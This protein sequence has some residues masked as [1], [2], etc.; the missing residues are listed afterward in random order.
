VD[1]LCDFD[2]I[3]LNQLNQ[4]YNRF[5]PLSSLH[6]LNNINN[7][8][9]KAEELKNGQSPLQQN[10]NM[11]NTNSQSL[12]HH[13]LHHNINSSMLLAGNQSN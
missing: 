7:S 3:D 2:D 13:F 4:L 5:V 10:K 8:Q 6:R 1:E 9:L 12:R 11:P